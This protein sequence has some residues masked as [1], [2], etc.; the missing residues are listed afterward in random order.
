MKSQREHHP[1]EDINIPNTAEEQNEQQLTVAEVSAKTGIS[2]LRLRT[3]AAW[4]LIC[5]RY[6]QAGQLRLALP[7]RELVNDL[8]RD[9]GEVPPE[10]LIG[11]LFDEIADLQQQKMAHQGQIEGLSALAD[12]QSAMLDRVLALAG[13]S[14]QAAVEESRADQLE[15]LLE[16][17]LTKL[18]GTKRGPAS[19]ADR[20]EAGIERTR[21]E[22][23][24]TLLERALVALEQQAG[25]QARFAELALLADGAF[26]LLDR[27]S[28][29]AEA[30]EKEIQML[31][32]R[33]EGSLSLSARAVVAAEAAQ[34]KLQARKGLWSRLL[35]K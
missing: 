28:G 2:S 26:G 8:K 19:L 12:Q 23:L 16:R 6:D 32:Q 33:L 9:A 34:T 31:T 24:E 13:R 18:E 5:S 20:V 10:T 35:G 30:Q 17:A 25:L 1:H 21:A 3:A 14:Q 15:E 27:V 22:Q 7:E 29:V 11:V 4:G